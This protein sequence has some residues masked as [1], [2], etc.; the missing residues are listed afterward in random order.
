[1]SNQTTVSI[2]NKL[3]KTGFS[4]SSQPVTEILKEIKNNSN[5]LLIEQA[6]LSGK[7]NE[8]NDNT[9]FVYDHQEGKMVHKPCNLYEKVKSEQTK[10]VTWSINLPNNTKRHLT[11]V[12]NENLSGLI[13]Y[14]MD[15]NSEEES[16]IIKKYLSISAFKDEIV[17]IWKSFGGKGLGFLVK[18]NGL[19]IDNFKSVWAYL[20][21]RYTSN[22]ARYKKTYYSKSK[23]EFK[24]DPA[25][26]DYTRINVLSSDESILIRELNE[27]EGYK[28]GFEEANFLMNQKQNESNN[29]SFE[30]MSNE[31]MESMSVD[32]RHLHY[33]IENLYED[34][35][36]RSAY[37][38]NG[39]SERLS[40]QFYV[41]F[42]SKANK[43]NIPLNIFLSF[44]KNYYQSA[45]YPLI[46][47]YRSYD[48]L[49]MHINKVYYMYSSEHETILNEWKGVDDYEITGRYSQPLSDKAYC[50]SAFHYYANLFG[51]TLESSVKSV[52][53]LALHLKA[54]AIDLSAINHLTE[55]FNEESLE[56]FKNVYN[57]PVYP[58][59]IKYDIK[60]SVLKQ[61]LSKWKANNSS[62]YDFITVTDDNQ[63]GLK[64]ITSLTKKECIKRE[65][66]SH[67]SFINSF[68][69]KALREGYDKNKVKKFLISFDNLYPYSNDVK[70][71]CD[72][73]FKNHS[74]QKNIRLSSFQMK[75]SQTFHL[76][77]DEYMD[78]V[79]KQIDFNKKQIFS[80]C[81]TGKT[82][83]IC[84]KEGLN[85]I[86]LP[87]KMLIKQ[88]QLDY[89]S[90]VFYENEKN[91]GEEL[92]I[93]TTYDSLPNLIKHIDEKGLYEAN[94]YHI[95][96]DESQFILTAAKSDF[97]RDTMNRIL[98]ILPTLDKYTF[99]T[100]TY[101]HVCDPLLSSLPVVRVTK[102]RSEI[103]ANIVN[104]TNRSEAIESN[105]VRGQLNVIYFQ[106]KR[107]DGHLGS[108]KSYFVAK[109]W[110]ENRMMFI[111]SDVYTDIDEKIEIKEDIELVFS[112][113]ILNEGI[114][115]FNK[116][117]ASINFVTGENPEIYHQ[118]VSRFRIADIDN[119]YVYHKNK[120]VTDNNYE[121]EYDY[122]KAQYNFLNY[123]EN[124][125]KY[126]NSISLEQ[127]DDP[128]VKSDIKN[129]PIFRQN[130]DGKISL[131]YLEF[132]H[133]SFAYRKNFLKNNINLFK[134]IL[135]EYQWNF[136][137]DVKCDIV[138]SNLEEVKTKEIFAV[139]K[140]KDNNMKIDFMSN[141]LDMNNKTVVNGV[142]LSSLKQ[143]KKIFKLSWQNK[144]FNLVFK[145][146]SYGYTLEESLKETIKLYEGG[147]SNTVNKKLLNE[148]YYKKKINSIKRIKLNHDYTNEEFKKELI[149][150]YKNKKGNFFTE[151]DLIK[152]FKSLQNKEDDLIEFIKKYV[153]LE[154]SE[155]GFIFNKIKYTPT[156]HYLIS[157]IR[158][159]LT[160]KF[161]KK[162]LFKMELIKRDISVL[163]KTLSNS[164]IMRTC[165]IKREADVLINVMAEFK[166]RSDGRYYINKINI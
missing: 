103:K 101:L 65:K 75:F 18:A 24:I 159:Y 144:F 48:E 88:I 136:K 109:G 155:N 96:F 54:N 166:K 67:I 160:D 79:S 140:A 149:D 143:D 66:T 36:F 134:E 128:L 57:N 92:L 10:C 108:M 78:K 148:A 53:P 87:N 125:L 164:G 16:E 147:F 127:L 124:R 28:I 14:D 22:F 116:K 32:F 1:M 3:T 154:K 165:D 13:Y 138:R 43:N 44:I 56:C 93:A 135:S 163:I 94:D 71:I 81:N 74:Y 85:I 4:N 90:G 107:L 39:H 97:K 46:G 80:D 157:S 2:F 133:N 100:G 73:I 158:N 131:D 23:V 52:Y 47:I 106:N 29:A 146:L 76:E 104:Y 61:R 7:Y 139:E 40:Y 151:K 21:N 145:M 84:K 49:E 19:T 83:F 161:E 11:A 126:V 122:I 111:N 129:T 156:S 91:L 15:V 41:H 123:A 77:E 113:S 33:L 110:D 20:N 9:I 95:H 152:S 99:Y 105:C 50:E 42:A 35:S 102:K 63:L 6:R 115:L 162:E 89:N 58:F 118:F 98:D 132:A 114:D 45:K 25:T 60:E 55:H 120:A 69:F 130:T 142:T 119:V 38:E 86:V 72:Y 70:F 27:V 141:Y 34:S 137:H 82:T 62:A 64:E 5:K 112:T 30:R 37:G 51:C 153:Y 121:R 17:A 26:K 68:V 12:K 31:K 59:G 150:F 117:V 8:K